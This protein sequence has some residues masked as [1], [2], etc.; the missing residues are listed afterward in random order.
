LNAIFSLL[1]IAMVALPTG[2]LSAGF[3]RA[4]K[5]EEGT[6]TCPHCG[7]QLDE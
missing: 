4:M 1:G 7:E 3:L 2:I 6:H 5:E